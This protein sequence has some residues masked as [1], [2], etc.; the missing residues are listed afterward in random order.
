MAGVGILH[1]Q[2]QDFIL[3][4]R[5]CGPQNTLYPGFSSDQC[6]NVLFQETNALSARPLGILVTMLYFRGI[7]SFSKNR[8]SGLL[9]LFY[10]IILS[11]ERLYYYSH[12]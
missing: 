11:N 3:C 7:N 12:R 4:D 8:F 1:L 2:G 9:I 10:F 6:D 5:K